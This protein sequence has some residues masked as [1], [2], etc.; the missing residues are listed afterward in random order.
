MLLQVE[1]L[2]IGFVTPRGT[3]AVVDDASFSVDDG[4]VVAVVGE[5]GAG[6]TMTALAVLGL[7]PPS[8]MVLGGSVRLSGRELLTPDGREQRRVRGRDVAMVFQEPTKSL[9]PAF[10]VGEQLTEVLRVMKRLGRQAARLRARELLDAVGIADAQ[11]RLASYPHQLSGGMCQRVMLAL[12]LAT[13]P[14][15]LIA[16]EPTASLDATIQIQILDLLR[17]LQ[18]DHGMAVILVTHDLGVVA[19]LAD[20]VVVMYAGQT[21]ELAEAEQLLRAPRHPYTEA[22]L[23]SLPQLTR[24]SQ[25][26]P[27][28]QGSAPRPGDVPD[29]CRFHPRCRHAETACTTAVPELTPLSDRHAARCIRAQELQLTGAR[30]IS[31]ELQ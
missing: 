23:R 9:N 18:R 14:R 21:V 4:T 30:P 28:I 20:R 5:S 27:I 25:T 1:H 31:G 13:E 19:E 15:L 29:G 6:K 12:A 8:A 24:R 16:D 3:P 17:A 26:I 10:T 22:L 7:L 11:R 2:R